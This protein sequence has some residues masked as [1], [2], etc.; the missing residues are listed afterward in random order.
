MVPEEPLAREY[1]KAVAVAGRAGLS[2]QK[3][4]EVARL[5]VADWLGKRFAVS[6]EVIERRLRYDKVW[7]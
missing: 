2:L 3:V 7:S 1:R 4:T 5:Y 6:A